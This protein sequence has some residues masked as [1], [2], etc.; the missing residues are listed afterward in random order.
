MS[1][2]FVTLPSHSSKN[3]F[4]DNKAH[5]FKIRL[6]NPV[7][8]EGHGWKVGLF[9]ITLPDAAVA[10]PFTSTDANDVNLAYTSW[11]HLE[12]QTSKGYS[13]GYS[14][15]D[16]KDAKKVFQH[17]NG[18]E[19]MKAM[20]HLF[21]RE[22]IFNNSGPKFNAKYVTSDGKRTYMTFRWEGE[23]LVIDNKNVLRTTMEAVSIRFNVDLAE[24]MGWLEKVGDTY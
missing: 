11:R 2:F 7:R 4:P 21:E 23:D 18:V 8:L 10:L 9:N 14:F 1:D 16:T 19:F 20:I 3:E 22:R 12:P 5:H 13:Y 17:V 6:P 15:F 24:K